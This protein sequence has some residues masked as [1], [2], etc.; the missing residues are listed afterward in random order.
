MRNILLALVLANILYFMWGRYVADDEENGVAVLEESELGPPLEIVDTP[1]AEAVAEAAPD[2][3]TSEPVD[4]DETEATTGTTEE[5]V[6]VARRTE[7]S[8]SVGRSCVTVGPFTVASEAEAAREA[9]ENDGMRASQR[10]TEAPVFVGHWVQIRN[11]AN[12]AEGN[13]MIEKLKD[14]GLGDAYLVETE[15]EGLKI[16]LGLFGEM[17]RAERIELQAKSLDLPADITPRTRDTQVV[18][19]DVALP[20]GRGAG[21]IVNE[22]GEERVL[23]RGAATCP[24]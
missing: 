5:P 1:V 16:S 12:R 6:T 22:Y 4:A 3:G 14:G 15:D 2:E 17:A 23:L 13:A 10:S 19:V 21:N 7:F 18:F 24:K 11:V 20:P 8:A 9:F